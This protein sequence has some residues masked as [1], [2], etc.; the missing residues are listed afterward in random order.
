MQFC[1]FVHNWSVT[2]ASLF[3]KNDLLNRADGVSVNSFQSDSSPFAP[4][5]FFS[6]F[7]SHS[8]GSTWEIRYG[9]L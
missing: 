2:A 6:P 5:D 4:I 1:C 9:A 8:T 3:F 7:K